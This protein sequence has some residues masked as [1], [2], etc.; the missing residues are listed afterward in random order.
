MILG[1]HYMVSWLYQIN[2]TAL[3]LLQISMEG[4]DQKTK[5]VFLIYRL[6]KK[7]KNMAFSA[8]K[9]RLVLKIHVLFLTHRLIV[10][11][12]R[13]SHLP[14]GKYIYIQKSDVLWRQ[15][16]TFSCSGLLKQFHFPTPPNK[17]KLAFVFSYVLSFLLVP[18]LLQCYFSTDND[19]K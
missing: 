10:S 4:R 15:V 2:C 7:G 9:T 18:S 5:H 8:K 14:A 16:C 6:Q 19:V 12:K 13:A 11:G 17:T 3:N 1:I